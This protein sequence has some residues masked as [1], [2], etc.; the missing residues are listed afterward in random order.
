[1]PRRRHWSEGLAMRAPV[2]KLQSGGEVGIEE[3]TTKPQFMLYASEYHQF[4]PST[5]PEHETF[6]KIRKVKS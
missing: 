1:M 5:I 6:K 2:R 4:L 3:K